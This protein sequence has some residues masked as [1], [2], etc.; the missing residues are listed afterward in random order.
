MPP[1][2]QVVKSQG[3]YH[4]LPTYPEK[5][6]YQNLT[7]I[8]TGANGISGYHMVKV[9]SAAP[10]RWNKI[11]C[12]SRRPPPDYFYD[13]LGKESLGIM[14]I[15]AHLQVHVVRLELQ[16]TFVVAT[17]YLSTRRL[18]H[19]SN[20]IRLLLILNPT[21]LRRGSFES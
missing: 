12:L 10:E 8:V 11:Y 4:G 15:S 13:G 7:A 20:Y 5:D 16:K 3:M 21:T 18:A 14:F 9:L 2:F 17:A 6:G 1:Q 19:S